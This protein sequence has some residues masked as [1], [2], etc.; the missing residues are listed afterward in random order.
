VRLTHASTIFA[1]APGTRG[2]GK[3]GQIWQPIADFTRADAD[4]SVFFLSQNNVGYFA[5]VLDPWFYANGTNNKTLGPNTTLYQTNSAVRTIACA[6]QY[7]MCNPTTGVCT[8]PGGSAWLQNSV[9]DDN[10]PAF[11]TA[12]QATAGRLILAL[13]SIGTYSPVQVLGT[14]ALWANSFVWSGNLSPGLPDNQWQ[15]EVLGWFQTNLARLQSYVVDFPSNAGKLGPRGTVLS[16]YG[17]DGET[18]AVLRD[19]CR[20]Q[21]V[22]TAGEVQNF[23]FAGVV[24]IVCVSGALLLLDFVLEPLV[25]LLGR[26]K[27][28]E[29]PAKRA[30]QADDKL[31]LLRMALPGKSGDA[32]ELGK[33]NTPVR[34]GRTNFGRPTLRGD[35][36]LVSY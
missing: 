8:K 36:L 28:W 3:S 15:I 21:L 33:G 1:F 14:G 32:W 19:Q 16:P 30:R 27:G 13:A 35:T 24:A 2:D 20:S 11:N 7:R 22:Q 26:R 4:I 17:G 31:H 9:L 6:D 23:H 10:T 29:S 18:D 12:Q 34:G 5:P 25:N